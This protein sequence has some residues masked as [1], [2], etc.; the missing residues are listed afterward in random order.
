MTKFNKLK[1][2]ISFK[3]F[4]SPL[5]IAH[6]GGA[7]E[8]PENSLFAF[9]KALEKGKADILET[10]VYSSLEGEAVLIHND[11]LFETTNETGYVW[12]TPLESLKKLDVGFYFTLDQGKSYPY[13]GKGLSIPTL[14]E[15]FKQFPNTII[16]I[17]IKQRSLPLV[18][19]VFK[20][21]ED[22]SRVEKTIIGSTSWSVWQL[23]KKEGITKKNFILF[24]SPQEVLKLWIYH[25]LY[26]TP[27]F[28]PICHVIELPIRYRI[29][30][31]L[32]DRFLRELKMMNIPL[33]T[34]TINDEKNMKKM[35]KLR[36][37]G[38]ITDLPKQF[39]KIRN[40]FNK[41]V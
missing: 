41:S 25:I 2:K 35:I 22:Y 6:R 8:Y 20:L 13:R 38:V 3:L 12:D 9:Q 24:F 40:Q 14:E 23:I 16:N 32:T 17:D 29:I 39:W 7:L 4:P 34:W 19:K 18:K 5:N 30:H 15:L 28:K 33:F 36:V 31:F 21:I 37:E 11:T 10:D 1:E 27:H 26:L